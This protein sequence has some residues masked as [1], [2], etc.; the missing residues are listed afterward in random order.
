MCWLAS[1]SLSAQ[2]RAQSPAD[3]WLCWNAAPDTLA[4]T[5]R[6]QK[7]NSSG[8]FLGTRIQKVTVS[9]PIYHLKLTSGLASRINLCW[10]AALTSPPQTHLT[11]SFPN[12]VSTYFLSKVISTWDYNKDVLFSVSVSLLTTFICTVRQQQFNIWVGFS[13]IVQ[14]NKAFYIFH[15]CLN[16]VKIEYNHC[17]AKHQKPWHKITWGLWNYLTH[18][19][20]SENHTHLIC[21]GDSEPVKDWEK[22]LRCDHYGYYI[23]ETIKSNTGS[24][25]VHLR[26]RDDMHY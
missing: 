6:R 4:E 5:W 9:F 7:R 21:A 25:A 10:R 26:I 23:G 13:S 3:G 11:V 19:S 1:Y 12:S 2:W 20:W 18:N 22:D 16:R 14:A 24:I 17:I 15:A 8:Q